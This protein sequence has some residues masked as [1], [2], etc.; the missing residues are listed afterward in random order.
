MNLISIKFYGDINIKIDCPL[1]LRTG[2]EL[3]F[4]VLD[5]I[6]NDVHLSFLYNSPHLM[7]VILICLTF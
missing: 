1:S 7:V 5:Y 6:V 4:D 3:K 2:K